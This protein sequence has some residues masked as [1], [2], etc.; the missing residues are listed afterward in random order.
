M[1]QF[2]NFWWFWYFTDLG[3]EDPV[4]ETFGIGEHDLID[5]EGNGSSW[6]K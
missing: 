4:D 5:E 2:N 6:Y 3:Q 1:N